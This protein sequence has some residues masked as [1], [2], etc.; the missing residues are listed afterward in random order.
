MSNLMMNLTPEKQIEQIDEELVGNIDLE[1]LALKYKSFTSTEN[2][3]DINQ[4]YTSKIIAENQKTIEA[5]K[6]QIVEMSSKFVDLGLEYNE[7]LECMRTK[8]RKE[9]CKLHK[10]FI[11]KLSD[12]NQKTKQH[13][14]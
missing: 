1:R 3:N 11:T 14:N 10:Q 13:Y 8:H 12:S 7:K 4:D 2:N 9:I 5:L 6:T